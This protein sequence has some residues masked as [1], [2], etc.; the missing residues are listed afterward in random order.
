MENDRP[1]DNGKREFIKNVAKGIA[2][3]TIVPAVNI[4][5]LMK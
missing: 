1:V 3:I 5:T 4:Q 2:A